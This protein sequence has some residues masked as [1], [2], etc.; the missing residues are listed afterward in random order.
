MCQSPWSISLTSFLFYLYSVLFFVVVPLVSFGVLSFLFILLFSYA[1]K[2]TPELNSWEE[3]IE[4][5]ELLFLTILA[6]I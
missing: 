1:C 2:C 6:K 5:R 4:L 3:S